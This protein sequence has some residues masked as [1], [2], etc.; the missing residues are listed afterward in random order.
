M[1]VFVIH[2]SMRKGNTYKLTQRVIKKLKTHRDVHVDEVSVSEIE[3]PFCLS[4]HLCFVKGEDKCPHY[5][6]V[7]KIAEKIEN[8]DVLIVSG[9]VYSMHLN[10]AMKNLIDHLSYYFHRPRLFN[11]QGMVITTTAGGGEKTVAKY[12]QT[13]LAQWGVSVSASISFKI[14]TTPFSLSEKQEKKLDKIVAA[15]YKD[16]VTGALF[17]PPVKA[18]VIH[19]AFR[20]MSA[21]ETP[22]S[23]YDKQYWLQTGMGRTVYPRK[24]APHKIVLGSITYTVMKKVMSKNGKNM[25]KNVAP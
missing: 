7:G 17:A 19:N 1:N 8:C 18:V 11:K 10:A 9:V 23:D 16:A 6:K 4:C 14:Q 21:V 13:T 2:G 5:D 15:F 24:I 20:G 12:L 25:Q 22:I 3:L